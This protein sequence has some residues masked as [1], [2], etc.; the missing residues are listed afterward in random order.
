MATTGSSREPTRT[1][2]VDRRLTAYYAALF[3]ATVVVVAASQVLDVYT[4]P[5]PEYWPLPLLAAALTAAALLRVRF[6]RGEDVDAMTL[7][8]AVL[9][10]LIFTF[11]TPLVVLT[12]AFSQVVASVLRRT[13]WVKGAFNVL[14]WSLAAGI[15]SLVLMSIRTDNSVSLSSMAEVVVA[16]ASVSL[17]NN[18]A[19]T[20]V[21]S[22]AGHQ[23]VAQSSGI[24]ARYWCRAGWW[25]GAST[26]S[27]VCSSSWPTSATR[28]LCCSSRFRW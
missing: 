25:V 28:R 7:F 22:I 20:L 15:G 9:A 14:Q 5:T 13:T 16:L 18:I 24:S 23:P 6:R 26:P 27:S 1:S 4:L 10:P 11:S 8:E 12:A 17:V 2:R 21:L 19:F 3:F